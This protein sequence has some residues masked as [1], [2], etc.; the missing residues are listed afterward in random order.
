MR[1]SRSVGKARSGAF[2][3]RN[4]SRLRDSTLWRK[5]RA[6]ESFGDERCG[7]NFLEGKFGIRV[8]RPPETH[9]LRRKFIGE[10]KYSPG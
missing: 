7:R 5:S 3:V 10:F 4:D 8:D 9:D 6:L 1:L 2:Q